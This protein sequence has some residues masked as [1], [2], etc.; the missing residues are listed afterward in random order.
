MSA[1][2]APPALITKPAC[3]SE[4][5]APPR[6]KPL[7]PAPVARRGAL[8]GTAR[9]GPV[10][11]LGGAPLSHQLPHPGVDLLRSPGPQTQRRAEDQIGSVRKT[12]AAVGKVRVRRLPRLSALV[13]AANGGHDIF[14][15]SAV[16][17]GVHQHGAAQRTGDTVGKLQPGQAA[18]LCRNGEA[19]QGDPRPGGDGLSVEHGAAQAVADMDHHTA[20]ARVPDQQVRAVADDNAL[21]AFFPQQPPQRGQLRLRRRLREQLRGAARAKGAVAVHRFALQQP[22]LRQGA[23]QF[24]RKHIR[25]HQSWKS[26]SL[27]LSMLLSWRLRNSIAVL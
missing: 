3:F 2:V 13:Q 5:C 27:P 24:F 15:L 22:Q 21:H 23:A 17:P 25:C 8:E 19:R 12:T 9:R 1:L 26:S 14:H 16:G 11:G 7:S 18:I 10:E 20:Y 4:T 6:R